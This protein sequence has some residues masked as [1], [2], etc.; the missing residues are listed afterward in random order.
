M[1]T[2]E[3]TEFVLNNYYTKFEPAMAYIALGIGGESGEVVDA[4]KK[5][6]RDGE[7]PGK[8]DNKTIA[9]ELG[10][11]LYYTVRMAAEFGYNLEDIMQMNVDKLVDR[12]INGK[13]IG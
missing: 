6:I 8:S 11:V 13:K 12:K 1:N 9:L 7:V 10:D 5:R 2:K 4:V 3:Y